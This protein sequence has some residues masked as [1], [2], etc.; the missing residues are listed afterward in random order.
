[1]TNTQCRWYIWYFPVIPSWRVAMYRGDGPNLKWLSCLTPLWASPLSNLPYLFPVAR[2]INAT[3]VAANCGTACHESC[4]I[5]ASWQPQ[6]IWF[7]L[8]M[9]VGT[10]A[11]QESSM[12]TFGHE[13][14]GHSKGIHGCQQIWDPNMTNPTFPKGW[15]SSQFQFIC[16]YFL[17]QLLFWF[18]LWLFIIMS[19]LFCS[20]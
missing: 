19:E 16:L 7:N 10:A 6:Y 11:K 9:Q 8:S 14:S 12:P 20:F 13:Q 15:L 17:R 1:M 4:L 18:L 2:T 5:V 3:T